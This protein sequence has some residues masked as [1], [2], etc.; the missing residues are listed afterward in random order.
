MFY[1]PFAIKTLFFCLSSNSL[2]EGGMFWVPL[3]GNRVWCP[4]SFSLWSTNQY[5]KKNLIN[6]T[7]GF[8]TTVN[9]QVKIFHKIQRLCPKYWHIEILCKLFCL[10]WNYQS[11][12]HCLPFISPHRPLF[13]LTW[14]SLVFHCKLGLE[15]L[16]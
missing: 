6:R 9:L 5:T 11:V 3:E 4:R 10:T 2:I 8:R 13:D 15:W 12:L 14:A 16:P 1:E 7:E